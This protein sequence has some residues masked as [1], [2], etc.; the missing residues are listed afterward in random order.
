MN[1]YEAIRA[2]MNLLQIIG[3]AVPIENAIFLYF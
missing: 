2:Y 1:V 3:Q